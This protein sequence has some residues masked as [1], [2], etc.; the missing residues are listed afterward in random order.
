MENLASRGG[1]YDDDVA[2][3]ANR[4]LIIDKSHLKKY[5]KLAMRD[6]GA[7]VLGAASARIG[8]SRAYGGGEW[9]YVKTTPSFLGYTSMSE[10]M[11][12]TT[13]QPSY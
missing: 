11:R 12:G 13:S 3:S 7:I 1:L 9:F 8:T 4:V 10:P 5:S 2:Y 6:A